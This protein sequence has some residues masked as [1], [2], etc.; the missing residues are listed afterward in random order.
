MSGFFSTSPFEHG[1][2]PTGVA[3][4]QVTMDTMVDS[5]SAMVAVLRHEQTVDG[6]RIKPSKIGNVVLPLGSHTRDYKL[7]EGVWTINV[8][9]PW[10]ENIQETFE[11]CDGETSSIK[12]RSRRKS[13][14]E[15]LDILHYS[16]GAES[17]PAVIFGGET[18]PDVDLPSFDSLPNFSIKEFRKAIGYSRAARQVDSPFT[19]PD[20]TPDEQIT[21]SLNARISDRWKRAIVTPLSDTEGYF[22]WNRI[23]D[24]ALDFAIGAV[25][26]SQ[27][28][29]SELRDGGSDIFASF[30]FQPNQFGNAGR[31][32]VHVSAYGEQR[33]LSLPLPWIDISTREPVGAEIAIQFVE[34]AFGLA[35][36][37]VEDPQSMAL[38][39]YLSNGLML[40]ADTLLSEAKDRLYYKRSNKLGAVA[41]GYVLLATRLNG[42]D[43]EWRDWIKN[44]SNWFPEVPDGAIL[45]G[46][47]Y[48]NGPKEIR[49]FDRA[50]TCFE[51][52]FDRG[53]PYYTLGFSW[54]LSG[55]SVL[56]DQI[57]TAAANL[58]VVESVSRMLETTSPFTALRLADTN[59]NQ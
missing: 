53:L 19:I 41:G 10:G 58:Q 56:Q 28:P 37:A 24:S 26:V 30:R 18:A 2:R 11:I 6:R 32:W 38:L 39:S 45:E 34:N 33:L 16:G 51:T 27:K 7:E 52:A 55:L 3:R 29:L 36:V 4:F 31:H 46:A 12:L 43:V 23:S 14:R 21:T 44:L 49:D 1:D 35:R 9:T 47:M 42:E 40:H 54:L 57:P 8:E 15:S 17:E 5:L 48:L 25:P 13:Q 22:N 20:V 50:A 59:S